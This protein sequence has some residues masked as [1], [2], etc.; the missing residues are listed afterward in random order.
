MRHPTPAPGHADDSPSPGRRPLSREQLQQRS[1]TGREVVL[2]DGDSI[3]SMTDTR[4]TITYINDYFVEISGYAESELIGQPHNTIRHPHMP[5][6]AFADM[7]ANLK[8]GRPWVGLVKNRCKNGDHYWVQANVTPM[9]DAQGQV[10]GYMS[11]RK[12]VTPA[13]IARAEQAYAAMRSGALSGVVIRNGEVDRHSLLERLNPLWRLSLPLRLFLL[14]GFGMGMAALLMHQA[15]SGVPL[16]SLWPWWVGAAAVAAYAAWWLARDIVG[17]SHAARLALED[18]ARDNFGGMIDVSRADEL[19][20]VLLGLKSMQIR[21]GF[22][23]EQMRREAA[24]AKRIT[25]ALEVAATNVMV[26][27]A[28]LRIV[29]ANKAVL[30]TFQ[31]AEPQLAQSIPGFR[32]SEIVGGSIDRFHVRPAHQRQMLAKM[33]APHSTRLPLSGLTFDLLVTPVLGDHGRHIGYVVEWKNRTEELQ[34]EAEVEAVVDAAMRGVMD[35]RIGEQG[36]SGHALTVA[37]GINGMLGQIQGAIE[38][39]QGVLG[40]LAQGDLTR[41]VEVKLQGS[42]GEMARDANETVDRLA[43]IV[44]RIQA[45][46]EVIATAA[47]EIASGNSDLAGRTEQQAAN[48]EETASSMEE[49]TSTVQQNAASARSARALSVGAT[50]IAQRGG[51][52]VGAAIATMDRITVASKQIEEIISVMDSI[53]F[54]TNILAL[55]AAVEAARAGEQGRGFAVVASE[56]RAL[57]Q[58]SATSA[59]EIK[60]LI[61]TSVSAVQQG[62]KQ[63]NEAGT[64]IREL[65]GEVDKVSGLVAEIS[66]ATDEQ[67]E[68]LGIVNQTVLQLDNTTQQ[69]AALVEQAS[70]AARALEEQA[71]GLAQTVAIFRLRRRG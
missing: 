36:K 4:G 59:K 3:V 11:V 27:D 56:V 16:A 2:R 51:E 71:G 26:A 43:D 32:A 63:V 42:F 24:A 8:Q 34:I 33:T 57:A 46:V 38:A 67:A 64:A 1:V 40:A 62:S 9:L 6:A 37:R 22:Q 21:L 5:A 13:Q 23:V 18:M 19:G 10:S 28:D 65:V 55:N 60:Q 35:R 31:R 53:A 15:A 44:G 29:F 30:D 48:L 17:R 61:A 41:K 7:W 20:Q 68:G 12:K 49:L 25:Q 70:A 54:Q 14:A 47:G 39:I 50:T 66:T 58:R 45:A 52:V 69:N